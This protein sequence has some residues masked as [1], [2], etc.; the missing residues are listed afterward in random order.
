[1]KPPVRVTVKLTITLM[2]IIAI[3]WFG[4]GVLTLA[5][6]ITPIPS[7]QV[8]VAIGIV[9]I[10]CSIITALAAVFLFRRNRWV[11]FSTV[12][13]FG[14]ILIMSFM[15]ELGWLDMLFI[16]ITAITLAFLIRDRAWYLQ[17]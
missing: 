8:R 6:L 17:N 5:N 15:D 13:L 9:A 4:F 2:A 1:M 7:G 10:A 11:Y 3:C 16:V 14:M 12:T